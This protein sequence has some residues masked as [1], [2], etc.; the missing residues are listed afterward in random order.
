VSG[1]TPAELFKQA[2][3]LREMGFDDAADVFEG[4]ATKIAL[5]NEVNGVTVEQARK[6]LGNEAFLKLIEGVV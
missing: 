1:L 2:E 6:T 5:F 3:L 4:V